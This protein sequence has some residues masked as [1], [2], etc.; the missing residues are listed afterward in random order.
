MPNQLKLLRSLAALE[1]V[2]V[3]AI[4]GF[5]A[6]AYAAGTGLLAFGLALYVPVLI[7]RVRGA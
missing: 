6:E 7:D 1:G 5:G 4:V 2:I 3:A